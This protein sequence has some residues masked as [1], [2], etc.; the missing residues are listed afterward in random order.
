L[1][2]R[3]RATTIAVYGRLSDAVRRESAQAV[4]HWWG[5]TAQ[6][7]TKWR[8]A[9]G[10]GPT[11]EGTFRLH[12]DYGAEPWAAVGLE[13][14]RAKAR[15]PQR[16][17]KIAAAKRG[18]P[19]P[20]H[21]CDAIGAAHR[22]THLTDEHKRKIG[23]AHRRLGTRPPKGVRSWTTEEDRLL[24]VLRDGEVVRQTGRPLMA[25]RSRRA[26]LG[27]PGRPRL[28]IGQILGWADQHHAQTGA[29]PNAESGPVLAAPRETWLAVDQALRLGRR[30]LP[31]GSSLARLLARLCGARNRTSMPRLTAKQILAWADRHYQR[32]GACPRR[33]SGPVL[34]VP[35]ERWS[36]IQAALEQGHRGLPG[37][38]SV[39]K[40]LREYGRV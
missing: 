8:A 18:K 15:D 11:N 20:Q 31:G 16:C 3:G 5:V 26:V 39:L 37:G 13:R 6:T 2:K 28:T 36:A 32:T 38:S 19:R 14:G 25:V 9:L 1:G 23:E 40:L 33:D 12:S 35:G 22:G 24:G 17:A 34:D 10:V 4:A 29:R 30:G 7:V 21:V 27:I